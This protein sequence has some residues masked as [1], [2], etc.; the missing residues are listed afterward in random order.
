MLTACIGLAIAP[1]VAASWGVSFI[2]S[3][4]PLTLFSMQTLSRGAKKCFQTIGE[5]LLAPYEKITC[6]LHPYLQSPAS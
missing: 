1:D 2:L 3:A 4:I 5:S 6:T